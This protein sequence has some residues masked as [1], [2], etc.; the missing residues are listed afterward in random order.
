V[1][2]FEA[3]MRITRQIEN[4]KSGKRR[5]TIALTWDSTQDLVPLELAFDPL[6]LIP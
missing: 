6:S 5:W 4:T 3:N 1:G 2:F